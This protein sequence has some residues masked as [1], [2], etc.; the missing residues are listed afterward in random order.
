MMVEP[1][2]VLSL[3]SVYGPHIRNND[4]TLQ[5]YLIFWNHDSNSNYFESLLYL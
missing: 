3:G 4:L 1:F 5:P 2:K